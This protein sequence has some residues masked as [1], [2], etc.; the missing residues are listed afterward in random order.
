VPSP[1]QPRESHIVNGELVPL[2]CPSDGV[3]MS[4]KVVG[5][6]ELSQNL[7]IPIIAKTHD[8]KEAHLFTL[9]NNLIEHRIVELLIVLP[10]N[11]LHLHNRNFVLVL[12]GRTPNQC[13]VEILMKVAPKP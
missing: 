11:V 13:E 12:H 1:Q 7:L 8:I 5:A 3:L 6:M 10:I 4:I 9:L 2:G